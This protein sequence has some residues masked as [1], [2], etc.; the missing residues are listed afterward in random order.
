MDI[1]KNNLII[2]INIQLC[3]CLWTQTSYI[4]NKLTYK[5]Y[6]DKNL[7]I[8]NLYAYVTCHRRFLI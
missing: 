8:I 4:D 2:F 7:N 6:I 3:H 1:L 5:D